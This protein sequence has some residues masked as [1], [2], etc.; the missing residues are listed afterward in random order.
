MATVALV[1]SGTLAFF[2]DT[3]SSTGN[4]FA[5]G[6]IDLMIDN[7][8]YYN[9]NRCTEVEP[10]VWQW[11]GNASYPVPGTECET[12]FPASDLDNGLLFFNFT[13]LKP[14]D[15]GEDT[16]SIHGG[17]NDAYVCM[18]LSVT[19]DDDLSSNEPELGAGDAAED[20][21]DTW[22]GELAD[23]LNF[24]WW[25]DDGDN[26]YEE[27]EESISEGVQSLNELA[28]QGEPW[29]VALADA[30]GSV[31]P[32]D[33]P[34]PGN[35]VRYI[36]KA[37]CY[38]DLT[39]TP[40][41]AGQG[42][43]P[44][45]NPGVSCD[46][47]DLG[48]TSQ[49]DG[50]TLDVAFTAVQARSNEGFVCGETRLA[51]I[52]VTKEVINDNG[53]NN[54]IADFQLFLDGVSDTNLTSGVPTD[55]AEGD[56]TVSEL[57]A[58]G[59]EATFG[60]DCD[61]DGNITL[62]AGNSYNCTITNDD[63][64]PNVTLIKNVVGGSAA[65]SDFK[66]R[67]NGTLVPSGSSRSVNSNTNVTITEDAFAGYTFTSITGTGCPAT[68]GEVFQLDEGEAIICT[69]TNTAN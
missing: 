17:S 43:N 13:D 14:D 67:V 38:G 26:V 34:V 48:N 9:G 20:V 33:G 51:T 59:Y 64:R 35:E 28:P 18:D 65:P 40:V 50:V 22:D 24:F 66:M 21:N 4:T 47:T 62:V 57:G 5:A 3:E 41:P 42:V 27:G 54:V 25:A 36:A 60:G 1:A 69:V 6:D 61:A 29:Q 30:D 15:E 19:S 52:T 2:G 10:G 55:V 8:S 58:Q 46:G 12:S 44:S 49:T 32:D 63:I 23:A 7:D 37:W 16:I 53:G 31:W 45:V 68:L 11:Q 56:Y 39:L